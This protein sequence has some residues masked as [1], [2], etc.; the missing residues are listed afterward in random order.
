MNQELWEKCVAFHGHKCPGLAIGFK[1]ALGAVEELKLTFSQ[2][3]EV[4]CITENDA[5]G[6]DAVQVITGC[7]MGKGNLLYKGTGKMAFTFYERKGNKS[8]RLMLNQ[9]N[10]DMDRTQRQEFLLKSNYQDV[11]KVTYPQMDDPQV[12]RIFNTIICKKCN[13]GAPEHKI[14]LMGGE[15]LC[16]DC[17]E[18]YTRGWE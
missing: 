17:Y 4:V 5:C 3:E 6:V 8:V 11:F 7:T 10:E 9:F 16:L 15:K 2:D 14:R 13:E 18:S 1:A 12:A